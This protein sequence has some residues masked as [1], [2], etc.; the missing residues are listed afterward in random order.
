MSHPAKSPAADWEVLPTTPWNYGLILDSTHPE[1]SVRIVEKTMG[2]FPF[3]A[4]GTPIELVVKGRRIPDWKFVNGSAGPL[5]PSPVVS[6]EK[7]ETLTLLPYGAAKL[8]VT[9]FPRLAEGNSAAASAS[10][11]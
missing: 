11:R 9:A 4:D 10:F 3:S 5:P 1:D 8:R 6:T 2:Q 7:V